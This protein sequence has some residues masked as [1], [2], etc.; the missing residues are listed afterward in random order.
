[1]ASEVRNAMAGVPGPGEMTVEL[2][3]AM[4]TFPRRLH[5]PEVPQLAFTDRYGTE[6][7]GG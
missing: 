7:S 5:R 2:D 3:E 1:V 4:R 6:L